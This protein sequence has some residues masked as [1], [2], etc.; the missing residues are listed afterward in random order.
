[1]LQTCYKT[2][3]NTMQCFDSDDRMKRRLSRRGNASISGEI[4]GSLPTTP[5]TLMERLLMNLEG[6]IPSSLEGFIDPETARNHLVQ[7]TGR[8]FGLDAA[9]WREWLSS[10]SE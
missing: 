1:M 8:D 9:K 4:D 2:A 6:K 10:P 3:A 7:M 5:S